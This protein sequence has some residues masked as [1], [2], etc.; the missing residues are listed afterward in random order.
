MKFGVG[1]KLHILTTPTLIDECIELKNKKFNCKLHIVKSYDNNI[2]L[3]EPF[4]KN[5]N[6]AF[7]INQFK[8]GVQRTWV[9]TK[10]NIQFL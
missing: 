9:N 6:I 1:Q 3:G 2:I 5:Y 4:F 7:N 8:I 10:T